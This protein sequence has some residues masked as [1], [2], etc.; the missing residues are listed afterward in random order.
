MSTEA[1]AEG[2]D[3]FRGTASLAGMLGAFG[4]RST[5]RYDGFWPFEK[6]YNAAEERSELMMP[7]KIAAIVERVAA[8]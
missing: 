4:R 3:L 6:L 2:L 1:I 8:N 7:P 5:N